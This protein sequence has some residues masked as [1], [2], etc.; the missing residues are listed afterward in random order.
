ERVPEYMVPSAFVF[1]E[2][3]PVTSSGKVDRRAL[4]EPDEQ[5]LEG[6]KTDVAPRTPT[7]QLLATIWADVLGLKEVGVTS[8]FFELGGDSILTI[9]VVAKAN[10]AGLQLV[11]KQLFQCQT[12]AKLAA[13]AGTTAGVQAEQSVVT[14]AVPLT[15]IQHWLFERKLP[16][17]HHFNMGYLFEVRQEVDASLVQ[18][19]VRGLYEHHDALRMRFTHD[20]TGWRQFN[21]GLEDEAPFARIDLAPLN[22]DEQRQTIEAE[23]ARAQ[24]SLNLSEGPLVRVVL[25]DRGA[26]RTA[27][28][29]FV[30]HHLV[31]DGVSW[32]ILLEDFQTA[33]EQLRNGQPVRLPLKT[34]SL[35]QWSER[36][37]EYALSETAQAELDY[38]M[39]QPGGVSPLPVDFTDGARLESSAEVLGVALS[40]EETEA[41]LREVPRFR[42]LRMNHILLAALGQSLAS[43]TGS[44]SFLIELEGHGREDV[45]EGVD[46]SRTVGWFTSIFPVRLNL[47]ESSTLAEVLQSVREGLDRVPHAGIGY[48]LLRYRGGDGPAAK[49]SSLPRAEISFNYLGQTDQSFRESSLFSVAPESAGPIAGPNARMPHVLY[50]NGIV[51]QGRLHVRFK[52]S[53][54]AYRKATIETLAQSYL[55]EL[56]ALIAYCQEASAAEWQVKEVGLPLLIGLTEEELEPALERI[57]FAGIEATGAAARQNVEAV[58]PLSPAQEGI[59]FHSIYAPETGVYVIQLHCGLKGLNV[60]AVERAWQAVVDRHAI[61][62]TAFVWEN[63]A[64]P[65]QIVGR[66]VSVPWQHLDWRDLPEAEQ[67]ERFQHYLEEDRT[68]G[69]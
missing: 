31:I 67:Q 25:F 41:L 46:V 4:P 22:D 14:G 58:Y 57:Q 30:V 52:Y 36:L 50:V 43:W 55:E 16:E 54:E 24:A 18:Q 17:L 60:T 42:R 48:G 34:T 9:Q 69:F 10:Q 29:L 47:S 49:L 27:R 51:F 7:E 40:V 19:S 33:Y 59:L 15:P 44:R 39:G 3:L 20:A 68:H 64:R 56:R 35:K 2:A 5:R 32:R 23:A 66:S 11:P 28:L 63:V 26:G 21:A 61:L 12:I 8:N 13:V 65:L 37:T 45:V 6:A 38:W 53:S 62:R 1:I